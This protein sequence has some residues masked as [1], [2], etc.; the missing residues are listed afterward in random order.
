[1]FFRVTFWPRDRERNYWEHPGKKGVLS[2]SV[3]SVSLVCVC[4]CVCV[5][6]VVCVCVC[7]CVCVYVCVWCLGTKARL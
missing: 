2:Y 6:F 4:V 3:Y 1:M 5:C 7:V